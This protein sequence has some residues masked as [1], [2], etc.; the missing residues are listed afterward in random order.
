MIRIKL[1]SEQERELE[2]AFKSTDDRRLRDRI[3]IVLMAHRGRPRRQITQDVAVDRRTVQRWL[4]AYLH[5]GGLQGLRPLKAPGA[6]PLIP[7]FLAE[8]VRGWV[9]QGPAKAAGLDRAGWTHEELA[10]H[11]GRACG[12]KVRRSAVGAFCRRHGIRPYRPTYHYLRG[13]PDRQAEALVELAELRRAADTGELV[14]LA[15]DEARFPMVPTLCATL[16]VKGHRPT[17]G[18]RDCKDLLYVFGSVNCVDG[19]LHTRTLESPKDAK[20]ATGRSKNRRL[21]EA[22]VKHLEDAAKAYPAGQREGEQEPRRVVMLV[23][24]ASW[25]GGTPVREVLERHPHLQL[26]RLPS[27][28]PKLNVIERLWKALRRR[29][30]HNRLFETLRDLKASLRNSLRYFQTM[31]SR[32]LSLIGGCYQNRTQSAGV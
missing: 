24:N 22:F 2:G 17:V 23:D 5:Q 7:P 8:V 13:D 29:A 15:Q 32:V 19:T 9:I 3:Q 11:L 1:S 6:P 12:I 10:A 30:T 31:T 25:H 27:Y 21:Q 18:T 4:N 26:K 16:G 20:K 14:L 28:S